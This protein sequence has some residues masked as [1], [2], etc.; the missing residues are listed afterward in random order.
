MGMLGVGG[1]ILGSFRRLV[2]TAGLVMSNPDIML[3]KPVI[4]G[5]HIAVESLL[6]RFA[7][8]ETE[9]QVLAAHPRL[10]PEH[11]RA[12]FEFP[13]KI[14]PADVVYPVDLRPA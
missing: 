4:A 9:A 13:A 10:Q 8:G 5:T 12:A 11:F 2:M 1:S 3:G 14:L 6:E 7:A